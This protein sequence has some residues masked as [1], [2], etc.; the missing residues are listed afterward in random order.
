MIIKQYKCPK[1]NGEYFFSAEEEYSEICQKCGNELRLWKINDNGHIYVVDASMNINA[2]SI[3]HEGISSTGNDNIQPKR[4]TTDKEGKALKILELLGGI[5][6]FAGIFLPFVKASFLGMVIEKSFNNLAPTDHLFFVVI[7]CVG[8]VGAALGQHLLTAI[9]GII[10][11]GLLFLETYDYFA[12][13]SDSEFGSP[14]SKGIG[15]YCMV[16]GLLLMVGAGFYAWYLHK[17]HGK[18]V[19]TSSGPKVDKD[20]ANCP[21]CEH[22]ISGIIQNEP[23]DSLSEKSAGVNGKILNGNKP[24]VY[25]LIAL[26]IIIPLIV[27]INIFSQGLPIGGKGSET[28]VEES[29]TYVEESE[30]YRK[31]DGKQTKEKNQNEYDDYFLRNGSR[32]AQKSLTSAQQVW[33]KDIEHI[34]ASMVD[35]GPLNDQAISTGLT[36]DDID[37]IFTCVC[38]DHPEFFYVEG[39]SYSIHTIGD[40]VVGYSFAGKYTMTHEEAERREKEI[41]QSAKVFLEGLPNGGKGL[42]DYEK[43]KYVYEKLILETEYSSDAPDNQ[44]IYSVLVGKKSVGQ[45]YS[46]AFQ[47]LL[48]EVGVECTLVQGEMQGMAHGWN[49]VKADGEYYYVDV[50]WG[51]YAYPPDGGSAAAPEILYDYL[52]VTTEEIAV[53]M[54][55]DEVIPLPVCTATDDNYFIREDAYFESLDLARL[56]LLFAKTTKKNAWQ[57][58]VKCANKECFED[59]KDFLLAKQKI[60]DYYPDEVNQITYYQYEDLF[61]LTFWVTN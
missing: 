15:F 19:C 55:I 49:L 45:G 1:C 5:L 17:N 39:Y 18:M 34:L 43:I 47:Y 37:K 35:E 6:C 21:T 3:R 54:T 26:G 40:K 27:I 14:I 9:M 57:V 50:T 46:K 42:D 38:I 32:Y 22:Q 53:A 23:N 4:E 7:S 12:S 56:Q 60:F 36:E 25:T 16:I 52:L 33:Y 48:N 28:F 31:D 24:L 2:D 29:E 11:G 10:Y 20:E 58:S 61:C 30:T 59:M 51:D 13:F 8:I 41:E 44:T